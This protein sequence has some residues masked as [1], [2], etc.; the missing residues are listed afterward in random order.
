M[1]V[2]LATT[3]NKISMKK[4]ITIGIMAGLLLTASPAFAKEGGRGH[5]EKENRGR[6]SS[7]KVVIDATTTAQMTAIK[8]QI[9]DL[10]KQLAELKKNSRPAG[11]TLHKDDEKEH[12]S[13]Q[14]RVSSCARFLKEHRKWRWKGHGH[15][16]WWRAFDQSIPAYCK[17]LPGYG[18]STPPVVDTTAPIISGIVASTV[19][20]TSESVSWTTNEAA[21]SKIFISTTSPVLTT[22]TPTWTDGATTTAHGVQLVSLL[23]NTTYYFIIQNTDASGNTRT[24][25]QGSFVT[26]SVADVTAP[27]ISGVAVGSLSTSSATVS[28]NTNESASS[29]VYLSTSS[30]VGTSSATWTN[31]GLLSGHSAPLAGLLPNTT[32]Y[33]IVQATDAS[34]NTAFSAQGSFTTA[35]LDVTAP[36]IS[37]LSAV[38]TGSTTASVSWTTNENASSKVYYSSTSP[39]NL[40]TAATAFDPAY[41]LVRG[42]NLSGLTTSTTYYVVVESR[43][44][45]N[46]VSTSSQTSFTTTN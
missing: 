15:R 27:V 9:A 34:A 39:V 45:S 44:A 42:V 31:A 19:S 25:A 38:P 28:W 7:S 46:N 5:E 36:V 23:P 10:N 21:T 18:T 33:F 1:G 8:Q 32:Y 37:L 20:S 4:I 14:G 11:L 6:G 22:G 13:Y 24:S 3:I 12:M 29:K 26:G 17:G 16:G 2:R 43:D 30:P 41:L 40:G 35:A